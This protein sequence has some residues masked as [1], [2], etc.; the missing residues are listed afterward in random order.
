MID[1]RTIITTAL[2]VI[3]GPA[4]ARRALAQDRAGTCGL[5]TRGFRAS[6][7]SP[8]TQIDSRGQ[9]ALPWRRRSD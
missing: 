9:N 5:L 1:R 8:G 2:A 6:I 3:A 4:W 7:N